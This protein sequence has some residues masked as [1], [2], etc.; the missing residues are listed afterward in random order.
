MTMRSLLLVLLT[1]SLFA[2][3]G[4]DPAATTDGSWI[5][6]AFTDV[7]GEAEMTVGASLDGVSIRGRGPVNS[8]FGTLVATEDGLAPSDQ[9]FGSTMMAGMPEAMAAEQRFHRAL[10]AVT[11]IAVEDDHLVMTG[12]GVALRWTR[13]ED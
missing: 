11:R 7:K 4:G 5:L 9:P 12:E 6:T 13:S 1:C 10:G 3:D 2:A 8:W